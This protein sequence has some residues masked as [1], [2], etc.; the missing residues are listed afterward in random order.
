MVA[1]YNTQR[2]VPNGGLVQHTEGGYLMV[3]LY[4]TQRGVPNGGLVQHTEGGT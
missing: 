1:L 3:A 2:G 4:N